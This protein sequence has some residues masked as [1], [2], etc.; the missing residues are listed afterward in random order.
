MATKEGEFR[1]EVPLDASKIEGFQPDQ[2]LKVLL[3]G[4]SGP[5]QSQVVALNS[6]GLGAAQFS[7][8][9][10]SGGLSIL[11]GPEA[12]SDQDLQNMQT[13]TVSVS[14]AQIRGL[15]ELKF[16]AILIPPYYRHW[17]PRQLSPLRHPR[18]RRLRRR[19]PRPRSQGL[20][21]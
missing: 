13:L 17:W 20:R 14:P 21:P 19:Q 6:K 15:S 5:L 10:Q 7:I 2:K 4:R 12:A 1:L 8:P 9:S 16:S 11:V 3:V 18:T